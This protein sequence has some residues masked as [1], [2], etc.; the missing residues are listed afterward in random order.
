[1]SAERPPLPL[2]PG[3]AALKARLA[4]IL[5]VDHAG[6]YGA[7]HIYRGQRAVFAHSPRHAALTA[8]LAEMERHEQ[9]HLDC[10]AG[11]LHDAG[12]RPTALAPLWRV[13]GFMMGAVT[14]LMGEKA[15]HAC[16]AAVETVIE[17][18]YADQIIQ[19]AAADPSLADTLRQFREDELH[20]RDLALESGAAQAPGYGVLSAVIGGICK[21]AIKV[22]EKI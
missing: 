19:I 13:G 4:E 16:T 10:F 6:E 14:A 22:S 1:M 11:L 20:H 2:P 12:T 3:A 15:A 21:A 17:G 9:E 7:V 18:H 5:R 8:Q